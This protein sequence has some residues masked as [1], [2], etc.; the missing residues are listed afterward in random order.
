MHHI[1]SS[2][3][4]WISLYLALVSL[5]PPPRCRNGCA[6]FPAIYYGGP[7]ERWNE[8][9]T[10]CELENKTDNKYRKLHI[11]KPQML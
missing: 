5:G 10:I 3:T 4:D 1:K 8:L 2:Q 6:Y 11:R 7:L 9:S